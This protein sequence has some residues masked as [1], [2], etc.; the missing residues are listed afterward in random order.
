MKKQ[1]KRIF[2]SNNQSLIE[3]QILTEATII[4]ARRKESTD[5][6][7]MIEY[8]NTENEKMVQTL[9]EETMKISEKWR[10]LNGFV[11]NILCKTKLSELESTI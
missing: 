5:L 8:Y 6:D 3:P 1:L 10:Y 7:S 2:Y 9:K 11:E 4:Q